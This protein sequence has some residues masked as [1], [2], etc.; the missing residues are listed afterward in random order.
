MSYLTVALCL[1]LMYSVWL[2]LWCRL[3]FRAER[4][5]NLGLDQR[6]QAYLCGKGG[7]IIGDLP[8]YEAFPI[9][10]TASVR[11]YGEG[12]VGSGRNYVAGTA[13]LHFPLIAPVEVHVTFCHCK[14]NI[15]R[16]SMLSVSLI[17]P[18]HVLDTPMKVP[19]SSFDHPWSNG[20][21]VMGVCDRLHVHC[22]ST[23]RTHVQAGT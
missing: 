7:A 18:L 16:D 1:S 9:G 5:I 19:D 12:S 4:S 13:E 11:G 10:G 14:C 3:R 22:A 20:I 21:T 6:L 23:C 2:V 15:V 17:P 8:P